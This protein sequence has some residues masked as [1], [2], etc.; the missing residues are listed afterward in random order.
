MT[1]ECSNYLWCSYDIIGGGQNPNIPQGKVI[2]FHENDIKKWDYLGRLWVNYFNIGYS[3][4]SDHGYI[5]GDAYDELGLDDLDVFKMKHDEEDEDVD[6]SLLND[7]GFAGISAADSDID[8]ELDSATEK[9]DKTDK[10]SSYF[11]KELK[12]SKPAKANKQPKIVDDEQDA[13]VMSVV[14]EEQGIAKD[15]KEDFGGRY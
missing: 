7:N 5:E 9:G 13:D 1:S 14:D 10:F 2:S 12:N 11:E 4:G 6:L 8:D 3:G 15:F